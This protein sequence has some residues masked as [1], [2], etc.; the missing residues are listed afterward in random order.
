MP[1]ERGETLNGLLKLAH[2]GFRFSLAL[3][4]FFD[5]MRRRAGNEFL[6][7]ELGGDLRDL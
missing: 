4:L 1:L 7:G 2:C 5:D 6:V 3:A